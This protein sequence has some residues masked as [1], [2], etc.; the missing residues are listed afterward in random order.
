LSSAAVASG[1]PVPPFA[2]PAVPVAV[3]AA[4]AL[5]ARTLEVFRRDPEV[6]VYLSGPGPERAGAAARGAIAAGARA[7]L[8]F[9]LA[10]GLSRELG[11]GAI[12]LPARV[13]SSSGEWAT[14]AAW[15]QRVA[16]GIGRRFALSEEAL[17]SALHVVTRPQ[18]KAELAKRTG[19]AA[20]DME[21]AAVAGAAAEAGLPYIAIRVVADG[22]DDALPE[23][24]ESLL[25]ADGH[26]RYRGLLS[27]LLAPAEFPRL[28]VLARRSDQARRTLGD[29]AV[30]F[31]EFPN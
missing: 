11:C 23:R 16:E 4:L 12:V 26:T 29:L 14:D 17:Y 5:E 7:L 13:L 22:P 30:H 15:R 19:A 10:G 24:I 3:I 6:C 21:S 20:V 8:S 2:A 9:G 28:L 31:A 25:T 18:A 27:L 1:D